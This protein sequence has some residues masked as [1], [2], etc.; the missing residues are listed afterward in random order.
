MPLSV[1]L[2]YRGQRDPAPG[3]Q[4]DQVKRDAEL[5]AG[6]VV[7]L[8]DVGQFPNFGQHF[9]GQV[10]FL[11]KWQSLFGRDLRVAGGV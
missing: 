2:P 8:V 4:D 9:H 1:N 6:Q 3:D 10:G 7:V 11:K 5:V